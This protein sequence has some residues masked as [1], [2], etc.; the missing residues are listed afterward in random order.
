MLTPYYDPELDDIRLSDED[1]NGITY[2][3]YLEEFRFKD[4]SDGLMYDPLMEAMRMGVD[5]ATPAIV[6]GLQLSNPTEN[7]INY[8]ADVSCDIETLVTIEHSLNEDMS[9]AIPFVHGVITED[10]SVAGVLGGLIPGSTIYV[11]VKAENAGGT[12][13]SSVANAGLLNVFDVPITGTGQ[14]ETNYIL[15]LN[16]HKGVQPTVENSRDF[17]LNNKCRSDF[18]DVRFKTAAGVNLPY[19][20]HSVHNFDFQYTNPAGSRLILPNGDIIATGVV[21]NVQLH[22]SVDGGANWTALY[23]SAD[24]IELLFVDSRGYIYLFNRNGYKLLRSTDGGTNFAEVFNLADTSS[25]IITSAFVEDNDGNLY[26]G[27]YQLAYG[28]RINKSTDDGATWT[29]VYNDVTR[30][31]VHSMY[32]DT[33]TNYIYA[34]FDGNDAGKGL[35]RSVDGGTNWV[36]LFDFAGSDIVAMYAGEGFRL[37]GCGESGGYNG[38][39]IVKTTDDAAFTHV[40]TAAQPVKSIKV[41]D[42]NIYAFSCSYTHNRYPQIYVSTDNGDT[43]KT[44]KVLDYDNNILHGYERTICDFRTPKTK[45]DKTLYTPE[46]EVYNSLLVDGGNNYQGLFYVKIPTL[47]ADGMTLKV[48]TGNGATDVSDSTIFTN[49][50]KTGLVGRWKINEGVGTDI[51]D[52]SGN[53]RHGVLGN[54]GGAWQNYGIS[55]MGAITPALKRESKSWL[56]AQANNTE[57]ITVAADAALQLDKSFTVSAWIT[58]NVTGTDV[59]IVDMLNATTGWLIKIGGAFHSITLRY[60]TG[61]A[62]KE[63]SSGLFVMP[64]SPVLPHFVGMKIDATGTKVKFFVDGFIS[65]EMTIDNALITPTTPLVIGNYNTQNKAWKGIIQDVQ[66]YNRELTDLEIRSLYEDR[67]MSATEAVITI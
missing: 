45:T 59:P 14:E 60:S 52:S 18:N 7:T 46:N 6:T 49:T 9:D 26:F 50:A 35:L 5:P 3:P 24:S 54:T 53:N 48:V 62:Y 22:K 42:G 40:L 23:T 2:D 64:I 47:P 32:V 8:I 39:G 55:R 36:E 43:W 65:A 19:Y 28:G 29:E 11:R 66:L 21:T 25:V 58:T 16:L 56:F 51:L 4:S 61:A 57:K 15:R 20:K 27:E 10:T 34:G 44:I 1:S 67:P 63:K 30:Q 13:Y 33:Y 41:I 38:T 31:H 17:Y 12:S 37:F